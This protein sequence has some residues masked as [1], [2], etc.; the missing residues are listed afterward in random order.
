MAWFRSGVSRAP[1]TGQVSGQGFKKNVGWSGQVSGQGVP[2]PWD[3]TWDLQG[4]DCENLKKMCFFYVCVPSQRRGKTRF[5]LS[6]PRFSTSTQATQAL[7]C[8]IERMILSH[9]RTGTLRAAARVLH[10]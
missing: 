3:L 7:V 6:N 8:R 4:E 10:I 1:R 5:L 9:A 2:E